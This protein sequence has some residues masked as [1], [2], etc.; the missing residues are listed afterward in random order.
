MIKFRLFIFWILDHFSLKRVFIPL[1]T[2]S[3]IPAH[4]GSWTG[5]TD[6]YVFGLRVARFQRTK[7]WEKN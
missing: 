2:C 5:V 1:S 4:A 3:F 6:V 7:P